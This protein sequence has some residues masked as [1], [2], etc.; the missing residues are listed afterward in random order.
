PR[1]GDTGVHDLILNDRQY[2]QFEIRRARDKIEAGVHGAA[3]KYPV[4]DRGSTPASEPPFN[5]AGRNPLPGGVTWGFEFAA[6][7]DKLMQQPRSEDGV[8]SHPAVSPLGGW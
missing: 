4:P 3:L 7:V 8:L 2:L 1:L 5:T 6:F